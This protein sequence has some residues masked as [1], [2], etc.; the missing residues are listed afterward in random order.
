ME[1]VVAVVQPFKLDDV[2][3]SE[4]MGVGGMTLTE[5]QGFGRQRGHTEVDRG[6]EYQVDFVPKLA[7][8]CSSTTTGARLSSTPSSLAATGRSATARSGR[9]GREVVRVRTGGAGTTPSE[10]AFGPPRRA[11]HT[12][13]K[14]VKGY[15]LRP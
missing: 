2:R 15:C 9:A 12:H 1:L 14:R 8:R 4:N 10:R 3:T 13:A 11:V 5:A 7:S 6:A